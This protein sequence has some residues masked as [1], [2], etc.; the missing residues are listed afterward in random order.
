[1]CYCFLDVL[2]NSAELELKPSFPALFS[3]KLGTMKGMVCHISL[4]DSVWNWGNYI[5][6][7]HQ[8]EP[9]D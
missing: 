5:S 2:S 3:G 9:P 1:M 7:Q 8:D 4:T 6:D